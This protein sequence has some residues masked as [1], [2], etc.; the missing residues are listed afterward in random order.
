MIRCLEHVTTKQVLTEGIS[1]R[2][3]SR[4]KWMEAGEDDLKK[5]GVRFELIS[6]IM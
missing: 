2:R 3:R 6:L 5:M 4:M 1:R